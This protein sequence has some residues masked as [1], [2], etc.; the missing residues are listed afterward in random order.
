MFRQF[1]SSIY[2]TAPDYLKLGDDLRVINSK[3]ITS[4]KRS[5]KTGVIQ[6]QRAAKKKRNRKKSK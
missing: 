2:L 6:I 4:Q 5:G 3:P 1:L